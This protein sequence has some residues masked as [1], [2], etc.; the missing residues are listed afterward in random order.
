MRRK[1]V[2]MFALLVFATASSVL[3]F[4]IPDADE[5]DVVE[6]AGGNGAIDWSNGFIYAIGEGVPPDG[7]TNKGQARL[8]AQRAAMVVAQR[9]LL[10]ITKGV[11]VSSETNVENY[12]VT[13]DVI[14]TSVEGILRGAQIVSNPKTGENYT[15][16]SDTTVRVRIRVPLDGFGSLADVLLSND[17]GEKIEGDLEDK[18]EKERKM[19]KK[20]KNVYTGLIINAQG[21][22]LK[23]AISPKIVDEEGEEVYGTGFVD[24]TY[25]VKSGVVGYLKD[26]EKAEE[27]RRVADNALVIEGKEPSGAARTDVVI[28]NDDADD[29]RKLARDLSFL[30]KCKVMFVID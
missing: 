1:G 15:Y 2:V 3:A 10:E 16:L 9:N 21:L 26:V 20:G 24:R 22:R 18:E 5:L 23:P 30:D 17:V 11:Q 25:A 4:N 14:R 12:M 13:S 27:N 6:S 29:V 8:M 28:S 19:R 7:I